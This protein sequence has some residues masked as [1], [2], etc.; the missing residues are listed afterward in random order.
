MTR[1]SVHPAALVV[2]VGLLGVL[3]AP[4]VAEVMLP[5]RM[6]AFAVNLKRTR[7]CAFAVSL[8]RTG[9]CAFALK[10]CQKTAQADFR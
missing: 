1:S 7:G 10:R 5:I 4:V 6:R 8:K 9:G 2:A 3:A